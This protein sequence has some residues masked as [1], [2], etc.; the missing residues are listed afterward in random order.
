MSINR[1]VVEH[2]AKLAKLAISEEEAEQFTNEIAGI[3]AYA[4][5]L[6]ALDTTGV[7]PLISPVPMQAVLRDDI[8]EENLSQQEALAAAPE[9]QD[10]MFKVPRIIEEE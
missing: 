10:G 1:E 7:D 8:V 6:N 5:K 9:V 3:L 4:E 2:V